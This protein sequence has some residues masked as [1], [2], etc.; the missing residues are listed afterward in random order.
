MKAFLLIPLVFILTS[1]ASGRPVPRFAP[2]DVVRR[3]R[4]VH[5]GKPTPGLDDGEFLVDTSIQ[6]VAAPGYQSDPAVAFDGVNFLVVWADWRSDSS[7]GIYATRVTPQGAVLDPSGIVV[8]T[9]G[10]EQKCPAVAFDGTNF[11]AVWVDNRDSDDD[12]FAARVTPQGIVLDP[13]G[14]AVSTAP[15][16]QSYPAVVFDG[17]NFLAV[18]ADSRDSTDDVFAARVTPQGTVLDPAGIAVSTAPDRQEF[19]TVAF[20]GVNSLVTWDDSRSDPA[21]DIYAARVTPQGTVL[22]PSGFVVSAAANTQECPFVA[23]DGTSFLV[24]WFD[25]RSTGYSDVYAARVTPQGTVL[26]PSGIAVSTAAEYQE[27]EGVAF[28]GTNFW[29]VWNDNRGGSSSD[30]Y[31]A[32]VTPQGMVLDPSGIPVSTAGGDQYNSAVA[33]GGGN[34]LVAWEDYRNNPYEPDVYAARVTPAGTVL[35]PQ[36]ILATLAIGWQEYP[37]VAFDGANFLVS[38]SNGRSDSTHDVYAARVTP[39]GAVLDSTVIAISTAPGW[40]SDPAIAFDGTNCLVTWM[41]YRNGSYGDIYATRVTPQG[42]VLDPSGIPVTTDSGDQLYPAIAFD[43]TNYLVTWMDDRSGSTYDIYAARVTPAGTVLDPSGILVSAAADYQMYPAVAFDGANFL[44]TWMDYRGGTAYDIYAARVTPGGSVLDPAG[45]PVSTA[46]NDQSY[47]AVAFDSTDFLV[48]WTDERSD[49][50]GDIYAARV[51]PQ[52]TVLDPSGIPVSTAPDVQWYPDV[53]FDGANFFV[54][55]QDYRSGSTFDIYCAR[56]SQA[57]VVFDSGPVVRQAGDQVGPALARGTGNQ[58][59]LAYEGW[60]GT[61]GDK[62][63]NTDRIWGKM[64]PSPGVEESRQPTAYGSQSTATIVR[65][66]LLLGK[67]AQSTSGQSPISLLDIS[68]RK[69]LDLRPGPN[70]VSR[71]APGVYFVRHPGPGVRGRGEVR[72]VVI[73][74]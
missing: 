47:P 46:A 68:G 40:H 56:V 55:W 51:T 22:D 21:G 7:N 8:S 67:P 6:Y 58:L 23:F 12:V 29:V 72:K 4:Q 9:A 74:D 48:T 28:D 64:N 50:Q 59:L 35:D 41:D 14:I 32:R 43:G 13:S 25:T 53:A 27:A 18:W 20:D 39:Q 52:G 10:S 26:D 1:T 70:D 63:Y 69:V 42:T 11:L 61:V 16:G 36:G 54:A 33:L 38:W 17:A 66:V 45:I 62:T 71:L 37:A 24:A 2:K 15:H 73:Q 49:W 3:V 57:G 5:T 65:G 44:V 30:I 19:P 31:A 34:L 60:A